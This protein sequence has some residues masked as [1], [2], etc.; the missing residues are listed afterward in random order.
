M[1]GFGDAGFED[2][3]FEGAGSG[4]EIVGGPA[5]SGPAPFAQFAPMAVDVTAQ[6]GEQGTSR[7]RRRLVAAVSVV[8]LLLVGAGGY[9]AYAAFN[10]SGAQPE[11]E[12]PASTLAV[13][14]VDLDPAAGQKVDAMQLLR[15]FPSAQVGSDTDLAT[16][17]VDR[18][19]QSASPSVDVAKDIE[20][21]LGKRFA[22]AA[23]P[24]STPA[25]VTGVLVIQETDDKAAAA[26]LDKL[27][28]AGTGTSQLNYAF[29]DGYVVVAPDEAGA[30]QRVLD[31]A[32]AAPLSGSSTYT[33]DTAALASDQIVTGWADAD[34]LGKLLGKA[35]AGQGAPAGITDLLQKQYSGRFV[36][37]MHVTASSVVVQVRTRGTA[38][39]PAH[40]LGPVTGTAKNAWAVLAVAGLGDSIDKQWA[41]LS[42]LP[43]YGS[44][45]AGL[46][47]QY[48]LSLPADLK[49][50]LGD[51]L[52]VS[53]GG[54]PQEP[55]VVAA[56]TGTG[57]V[58]A[59]ALLDKVL[60]DTGA[61]AGVVSERLDGDTFYVGTSQAAVD[62]AGGSSISADPYYATAVA[63]PSAAQAVL[64]VD[65]TKVW[66]G[67][68]AGALAGDQAQLTA[69]A[70][71]GMSASQTADGASV[72]LRVVLR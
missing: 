37:G 60:A 10:G 40:A 20:P 35:V 67:L 7:T 29:R 19:A 13:L 9:A 69:V 22:V 21:W 6:P 44:L 11:A 30:A 53:A 16:W 45:L 64:F 50:L 18:L 26:G 38:S 15:K 56:R 51:R 31:A 5:P 48:G 36:L 27:K 65:L 58:G 32:A 33:S 42:A 72:E 62:G 59:K 12:L 2:A 71:V 47:G 14:K 1:D 61:P 34:R 70:A 25:G 24:S 17:L 4:D 46:E 52:V 3:G 63:D 54:S 66:D 41:T 55:A 39:S 28:A 57:A 43:G 23:V 8:T 68:P 49:T